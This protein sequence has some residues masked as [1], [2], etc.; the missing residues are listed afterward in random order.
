MFSPVEPTLIAASGN[1]GI[2]LLDLRNAQ[3]IRLFM[4]KLVQHFVFLYF[5]NFVL[6]GNNRCLH[7]YPTIQTMR[8]RFDT[9]GARLVCREMTTPDARQIVVHKVPSEQHQELGNGLTMKSPGYFTPLVGFDSCCFAG[10]NDELVVAAS[11]ENNLHIWSIPDEQSIIGNRKTA[12][13]SLLSLRGHQKRISCVRYCKATSLLASCDAS[14]I[15][16]LWSPTE[17]E[18]SY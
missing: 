15:I 11:K 16:K 9:K 14:G 5:I 18:S 1:G 6:F 12:D 4:Y 2:R 7:S 17:K 13:Q 3:S 8:A 10:D